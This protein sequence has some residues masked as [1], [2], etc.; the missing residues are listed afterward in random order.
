[1]RSLTDTDSLVVRQNKEML[2]VLTDIETKNKYQVFDKLG[3]LLYTAM[4]E[5]GS[6]ILRLVLRALR[7]FEIFVRSQDGQTALRVEKPFRFFFHEIN[8]YDKND[9]LLGN[10][11]RKFSILRRIYSV[12]GPS[13]QEE[14]LLFG[15]LL[16]PWTFQIMEGEAEQGVIT[17]KW[18]GLLKEGFTDADNFGVTFPQKWPVERKGLFLGAVFLIDFVHFENTNN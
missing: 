3:Q 11:K 2:E 6:L 7:P 16:K 15:P 4:E 14:Y 9:R 8:V 17:K 13:G 10:V 5:G 18:S 12:T 1:M